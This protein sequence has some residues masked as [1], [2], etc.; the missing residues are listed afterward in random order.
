MRSRPQ[1]ADWPERAKEGALRRRRI[2]GATAGLFAAMAA[3]PALSANPG[4]PSPGATPPSALELTRVREQIAER[5]YRASEN[6]AGLQAPNRAHNLR[7]YFEPTGIRVHDRGA[8]EKPALVS[9][10]LVHVGREGAL[11]RVGAG[12]VTSEGHRVE[13]RREGLVEWYL[14]SREGLEQGF[15]LAERPAGEGPLV[16]ELEVASAQASLRGDAIIL[17]TRAGRRLRYGE[18][19]AQDAAGR[20]LAARLEVADP[21]RIRL[22]VDDAGAAYPVVVDPLLTETADALLESNQAFASLGFSVAGAGDVNGDGFDDVIV[23]A[24]QYDGGSLD[25]GAAFVFLGSAAGIS[26]CVPSA[27]SPPRCD[28]ALAAS[29]IE[30]DRDVAFLG[31]SV[32]GAGDVNSDG[33]DDVIVGAPGFRA[34]QT[35]EGAAFVFRGSVNGII[36]RGSPANAASQIESNR[37]GALLGTSVAGAGDVNGDGFDDVIVGA[38]FYD[39]LTT[40]QTTREGVAF[41]FLGGA[42]GIINRGTP[43]NAAAQIESNQSSGN[44]GIS[45]AGAGDVNGDG[46]DDVIVGARGFTAG[47]TGEGG[48]FVFLG[49]AAGITRR[50]N[51]ANAATR[52]ESDQPLAGMGV[53]VA[54]AGD[55]DG[56]G[57]DDVIVGAWGYDAG[58]TDEGAAFVFRGSASGIADGTPA[59]ATAQLESDQAGARLGVRVAGAGDVNGDGFD[60]VIVGAYLYDAGQTDEGAA[61]VFLGSASAVP[62]GSP[63]G[64]VGQAVEA[65]PQ[66]P[67]DSDGDGVPDASDNCTNLANASQL[68]AD[69]DGCGNACDADFDQNGVT[70]ST[71]LSALRTCF[72]QSVPGTGPAED[73]V[74]AES[75]MDGN[76]VVGAS[77]LSSLRIGFSS[78]PGPGAA[79]PW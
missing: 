12:N 60:D 70:G 38:P 2:A 52:L 78:A 37:E 13:I 23:G 11:A 43:N 24:Q 62:A 50:G 54:G 27:P 61:F 36:R 33:F 74:C 19:V 66:P 32:A 4:E 14:N 76:G 25:E 26:G 58:Q 39:D 68:D 49:S 56:D 10:K 3:A 73:P 35:D 17:A 47:Q 72:S 15:T 69:G 30:G 45:V 29:Q 53:S 18:L 28:P 55:V 48:A 1:V 9:L 31:T 71:D 75:D 67:A 79:C 5:E 40:G 34:G 64:A 51:P 59:T 46:F 22:V 41:V 6:G 8:S 44:L 57:F 21:Q 16:L 42:A 20:P 77:D 7:T 63:A 65:D